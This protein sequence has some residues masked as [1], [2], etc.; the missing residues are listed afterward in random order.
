[1][2]SDIFLPYYYD[3]PSSRPFDEF[4]ERV[5]SENPS[6]DYLALVELPIGSLDLTKY[7]GHDMIR[8]SMSMQNV[9][10]DEDLKK[11]LNLP[12]FPLRLQWLIRDYVSTGELLSELEEVCEIALQE[13]PSMNIMCDGYIFSIILSAMARNRDLTG[14]RIR[15]SIWSRTL[16]LDSHEE[17]T[18]FQTAVEKLLRGSADYSTGDG[19]SNLHWRQEADVLE[20]LAMA[21]QP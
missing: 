1:M 4:L 19:S 5:I 2:S 12:F 15:D 9:L 21:F 20:R 16:R 6:L 17:A 14:E 7:S 18:S 8:I 13:D 11:R 10:R 3:N